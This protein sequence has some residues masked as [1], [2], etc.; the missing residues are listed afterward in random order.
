MRISAAGADG[1]GVS[2]ELPPGWW[3]LP[4]TA[5]DLPARV[6]ALVAGQ[7]AAL[8][9]AAGEELT[10]EYD[11]MTS[12]ARTAGAVLLAGGAAAANDDG[13]IVVAS[14]LVAPYEAYRG[15][16]RPGW[17]EGP[18]ARVPLPGGTA[19]R[20]TWLGTGASPLGPVRQLDVEY[21]V[22]PPDPPSWILAFR[23]PALRHVV[24][25][26]AAFDAIAATMRP[27]RTSEPAPVFG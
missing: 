15:A 25:L 14:L 17:S 22:A 7:T 1:A 10:A 8:P 26:L 19:V 11:R 2:L 18:S 16:D 24:M 9:D 12:T 21:V 5:T 6:E 20:H 3:A 4:L 23:T 13:R 27:E